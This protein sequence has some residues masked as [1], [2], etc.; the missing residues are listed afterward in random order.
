M[1]VERK[2]SSLWGW[3]WRGKQGKFG[4]CILGLQEEV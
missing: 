4:G 2:G 3:V 1:Q